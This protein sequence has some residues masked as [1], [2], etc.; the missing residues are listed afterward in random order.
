MDK[1]I[2]ESKIILLKVWDSRYKKNHGALLIQ[3]KWKKLNHVAHPVPSR[4]IH[5]QKNLTILFS[6][7]SLCE[8]PLYVT[9][10]VEE[11]L[12]V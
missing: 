10:S 5:Y 6:F 11:Q 8:P 12:S 3:G 9:A 7:F 1:F 2:L 4:P